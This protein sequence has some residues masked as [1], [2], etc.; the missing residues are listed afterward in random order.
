VQHNPLGWA[1]N[2]ESFVGKASEMGSGTH[3]GEAGILSLISNYDPSTTVLRA[4]GFN[5]LLGAV[6]AFVPAPDHSDLRA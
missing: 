2:Q 4:V 3:V 1:Q 6:S 5:S